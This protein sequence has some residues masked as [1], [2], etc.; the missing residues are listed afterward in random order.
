MCL[1]CFKRHSQ[2]HPNSPRWIPLE[3]CYWLWKEYLLIAFPLTQTLP[4]SLYPAY[5]ASV[6]FL[7][8]LVTCLW[9]WCWITLAGMVLDSPQQCKLDFWPPKSWQCIQ[10]LRHQ[11]SILPL[12]NY[13]GNQGWTPKISLWAGKCMGPWYSPVSIDSVS[14]CLSVIALLGTLGYEVGLRDCQQLVL[15]TIPFSSCCPL[16]CPVPLQEPLSRYCWSKKVDSS[17]APRCGG[18]FRIQGQVGFLI[19]IIYSS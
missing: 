19:L 2:W 10:Q 7:A 14:K 11:Y 4:H 3:S 5:T 18:R 9:T 17:T 13:S 1:T 16:D 12:P 15:H 8:Q 6:V